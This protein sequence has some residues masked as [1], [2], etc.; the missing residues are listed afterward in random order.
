MYTHR[1]P[2]LRTQSRKAA[3]LQNERDSAPKPL[4]YVRDAVLVS[5]IREQGHLSN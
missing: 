3:K 5:E 4:V 1:A 2:G